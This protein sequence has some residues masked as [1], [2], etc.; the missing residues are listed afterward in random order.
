MSKEDADKIKLEAKILATEFNYIE[1]LVKI[2][3][4]LQKLRQSYIDDKMCYI[5]PEK[6]SP[7]TILRNDGETYEYRTK[8]RL[9]ETRRLKYNRMID[10]KKRHTCLGHKSVKNIEENLTTTSGKSINID[11]F[12]AYTKKS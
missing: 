11:T 5:D 10:I 6:R 1:D 3:S 7:V 4:H 8:R 9:K 2:D 12:I